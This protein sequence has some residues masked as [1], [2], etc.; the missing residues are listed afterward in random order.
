MA[1]KFGLL[2]MI[3]IAFS[4]A[5]ASDGAG[6]IGTV[7]ARGNVRLDGSTVWGNG[8]LF[9]GT[10]VETGQNTATLRLDSGNE[11]KL[12]INS[13]GVVYRNHLVLL[14]GRSELKSS[15]SPFLLEANGL[16]VAPSGPNILGVVSLSPANTVDVA[17]V[18]G[19][20]RIVDDAGFSLAHVSTGAA[21]AFKSLAEP[22]AQAQE[23]SPSFL[24]GV[25]G[26]VSLDNGIYSI[27][28]DSGVKYQL[29]TG[30]ELRKFAG[31]KVVVSG[32][33][34]AASAPSGTTELEVTS[35]EINGPNGPKDVG[36]GGGAAGSN[37]VLIGVLI[38]GGAA[39]AIGVAV[40]ESSKAP[41]SP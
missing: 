2:A 24:E 39:A 29:V 6:S 23:G 13:R 28:S 10:A 15:S 37:K 40:A 36:G 38:A 32:F 27:T 22:P 20:F 12:A 11:I 35:I 5:Y 3:L 41:A 9:D 30:K 14:Q 18:T 1:K 17:A 8:T 31:K 33:I 16:R 19:E 26:L 25:V 34:Q 21:M 7:S 4:Y